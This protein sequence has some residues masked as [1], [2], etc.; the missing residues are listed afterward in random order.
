MYKSNKNNGLVNFM[1]TKAHK[2]LYIVKDAFG[3]TS[4]LTF[5]VKSHLPAPRGIRENRTQKGTLLA[6]GK[7][8]HFSTEDIIF[9]L[10]ADALY[11]DLDFI[12]ITSAAVHGSYSSIHHLQNETVPLHSA[13]SLSIKAD[14]IPK[15][16]ISKAL[17]V[18]VDGNGHFSGKSSKLE[19]NFIKAQVREFGNYTIAVDT[20]SPV[21]R[22]VNVGQNKN[23]GKQQNL[24]FKI[25]DNLS[26]IQSYRGTLNGKWILMDFDAKS[27]LLVYTFDDQIKP[28]KNS[29]RLV[30][31]DAVGNETVYQATLTR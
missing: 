31:R 25:S 29:F 18:K 13:C 12:Y 6:C 2:V 22:P 24:S 26:G 1:D 23:V 3:N 14:S 19:N 15:V 30:V 5:W 16:L 27:N 20:I 9:D 11:E 17:I 28:G 7:S 4:R 8:N 10:P 21:I